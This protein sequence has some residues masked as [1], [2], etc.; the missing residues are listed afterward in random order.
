MKKSILL[1]S[2]L[3]IAV[4]VFA[5]E[6]P[7]NIDVDEDY[8]DV[9]SERIESQ[10]RM[11]Q[12]KKADED[13][14]LSCKIFNFG[15]ELYR[16]VCFY[17]AEESENTLISLWHG[18]KGYAALKM[19]MDQ[20]IFDKHFVSRWNKWNTGTHTFM[21]NNFTKKVGPR[22]IEDI[23]AENS[24]WL[25]TNATQGTLFIV[26]QKNLKKL[27]R[28]IENFAELERFKIAEEKEG[29]DGAWLDAMETM[30]KRINR[31]GRTPPLGATIPLH[32]K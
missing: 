20:V 9:V 17:P 2:F 15:G 3:F 19:E 13:T 1:I 27:I 12:F 26:K 6:Q 5:Q 24:L 31:E 14:E 11:E 29:A 8:M 18:K 4:G 7:F 30:D 16:K 22:I 21:K 23:Y 32:V 25:I 10:I 28:S